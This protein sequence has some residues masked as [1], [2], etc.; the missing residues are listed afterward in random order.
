MSV[1]FNPETPQQ[2]CPRVWL[3]PYN[4]LLNNTDNYGSNFLVQRNIKIIINITVPRL[5]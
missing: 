4:A 3:G 5:D 2:I 1:C